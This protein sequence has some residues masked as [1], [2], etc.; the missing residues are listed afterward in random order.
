MAGAA[1]VITV[2]AGDRIPSRASCPDGPSSGAG[3]VVGACSS[4]GG[5]DGGDT[6]SSTGTGGK[7]RANP[8]FAG[9]LGAG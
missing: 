4:S 8:C 1:S 7:N 3:P 9:V 5:V 2:V 6:R